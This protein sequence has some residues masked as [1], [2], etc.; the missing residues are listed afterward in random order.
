MWQSLHDAWWRL[1]TQ[2]R[3]ATLSAALTCRVLQMGSIV[4]GAGVAVR[5]MAYD[6]GWVKPVTLPC[7]VISVGNLTVGGTGKTTCVELITKKL[8]AAGRRVAIL[9]RGYGGSRAGYWL[10]SERGHLLINGE[11]CVSVDGLADE[12]QLLAQH[13]EGVP[14]IVGSRRDRTGRM[15]HDTFGTETIVLDDGFQHRRLRRDCD[16]VLLHARTPFGGWSM[17]PRGPMREPITA[18]KRAHVVVVTKADEALETLAALT[19]RIHAVS[20]EATIVTAVHEP[21]DLMEPATGTIRLPQELNGV[22]VGLLSSIGDPS[23]FETS[24]RR[25]HAELVWHQ[26][27][28]DHVRYRADHIALLLARMQEARPEMVV[29]TE[30]DW[31]RL[32][33]WTVDHGPWTVPLWILRVQMKIL[34]GEDAFDARLARLYAR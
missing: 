8:T 13:L 9:S 28:P 30:K 7:R 25:L 3:P 21:V 14:I 33:P 24:V 18:L 23:G 22:R 32:R 2:D 15:A 11:E 31:V 20:P 34:S 16:I 17:L 10:R 5:N 12:P 19:E 29:T 6:R 26:T 27:F 4:Y 1:A